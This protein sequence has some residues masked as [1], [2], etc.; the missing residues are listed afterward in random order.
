MPGSPYPKNA[1][2]SIWHKEVLGSGTFLG[3]GV[4]ISPRLVLAAK[5]VVDQKN[6]SKGFYLGLIDGYPSIPATTIHLHPNLDIALIDLTKE[7]ASQ[8]FIRPNWDSIDSTGKK[9]D[10]YGISRFSKARDEHRDHNVGNWYSDS[11]GYLCDHRVLEGFSGGAAVVDGLFVGI[12]I[13]RHESDQQT[14]FVPLHLTYE[15]FKDILPGNTLEKY[16]P[17]NISSQ[18]FLQ[19]PSVISVS[20]F[21]NSMDYQA[22]FSEGFPDHNLFFTG[23]EQKLMEIKKTLNNQSRVALYGLGGVGKTQI[24]TEYAYRYLNNYDYI[25]WVNADSQE[26]LISSYVKIASHLKVLGRNVQDQSH[27]IEAVKH[28]L[29]THE[30]WLLIFDNADEIKI[31][32]QFIPSGKHGHVLLTTQARAIGTM[33]DRIEILEMESEEGELFLLRRAKC[34]AADALL[35]AASEADQEIAKKIVE[36]LGGL[37]LALDQ[38]GAYIEETECGLA[39]YLELYS[40]HVLEL[41]RHRG[42]ALNHPNPVTRTW[43]LSFEKI[44][45]VSP[46]A[47]E[48]LRLCAFLHPDGIPE[49]IFIK[50]ASGPEPILNM[51]GLDAL[52]VNN[53]ISEILKYSLL[54]RI[55][56]NNSIKIH[57][58]VQVV[59]KKEMEEATQRL[60][61]ERAVRAVNRCFPEVEFD[62]WPDCQRLLSNAEICTKLIIKWKFNFIESVKLLNKT[63]TYFVEQGRFGEAEPLFHEAKELLGENDPEMATILNGLAGLMCAQGRYKDAKSNYELA[64]GVAR[65]VSKSSFKNIVPDIAAS[66]NGLAVLNEIDCCYDDA[67][68]LYK[69]SLR[70]RKK[71]SGSDHYI[72]AHSLNNLAAL[73]CTRSFFDKA[74]PLYELSLEIMKNF[75][76]KNH[77]YIS[78]S[79]EGLASTYIFQGNFDI[80]EEYLKE[81]L[82]ILETTFGN[83]HP[84]VADSYSNLVLHPL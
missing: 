14:L 63:A 21:A 45:N 34:I 8:A 27:V 43:A 39:V 41:L 57:R 55:P 40:I 64:L 61:S 65:K 84:D 46:A 5:H 33:M 1:I 38:A 11:N 30:R 15:W 12:I 7:F 81:S 78:A 31:I 54:R 68:K 80:A 17:S 74:K 19:P 52:A 42:I 62:K 67:E 9:V 56:K 28:W 72:V 26:R 48:L 6:F 37:P 13:E 10:F 29:T 75:F 22:K 2:I 66:L 44:E 4:F 16:F 70:F 18:N 69:R 25:F 53:A 79:L 59:L 82:Q 73:Y 23:R 71:F 3:S 47:V 35:N 76:N 36:Q 60:W 51:V 24:A 49:E 77:P 32:K 83:D 50:A 58:L 20:E